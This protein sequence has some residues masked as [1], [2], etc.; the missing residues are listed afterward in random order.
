M[1]GRLWA[2]PGG[3]RL[4]IVDAFTDTP[5]RGNPAA[6]CVLLRATSERWMSAV[7]N[8]LNLPMTAFAVPR[9]DGDY[10]LRWFT[11]TVEVAICGHAT[12][13]A[14][15]VL[16]R[17]VRF[18]TQS[19]LIPCRCHRDG[20]IE[21]NFPALSVAPVTDSKALAATAE[22]LAVPGTA[23]RGMWAGGEWRLVEFASAREVRALVPDF[24]GLRSLAGVVVAV[25]TP[26]DQEGADSACRVFEPASGIDEDPVTGSAHCVI[27]PWLAARTGRTEFR[28]QQ[29]SARGG[30]VGMR[31][32]ADRVLLRGRAVTAIEGT[33]R[34]EPD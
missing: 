33:L 13:A 14:V 1:P 2:V 10:D 29:L 16:G 11:P 4:T 20:V 7:A 18:H 27:A 23:I 19:G 25:A 24:A 12:L 17:D 21:M 22:A 9:S 28:G 32:L 31:V 3:T 26:G 34:P 30:L 6:V 8:E 15:H 5:F